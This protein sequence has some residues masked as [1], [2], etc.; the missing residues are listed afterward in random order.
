MDSKW[1][2]CSEQMP[3]DKID[4][5]NPVL[6]CTTVGDIWVAWFDYES[7]TWHTVPT[8]PSHFPSDSFIPEYWM[9]LPEV[10]EIK[11]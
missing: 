8:M 1:I 9:P 5:T 7:F 10:P 6:C 3:P 2:K 11:D 4:Q